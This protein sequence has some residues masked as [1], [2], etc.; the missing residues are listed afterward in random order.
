MAQSKMEVEAEFVRCRETIERAY[1]SILTGSTGGPVEG[2]DGGW[3]E[4]EQARREADVRA[5]EEKERSRRARQLEQWEEEDRLRWEREEEERRAALTRVW[6][7][8]EEE[9]RRAAALR[10]DALAAKQRTAAETQRLMLI[11]QATLR[12]QG[13]VAEEGRRAAERQAWE[14]EEASRR[15]AEAERWEAEQRKAREGAAAAASSSAAGF[16]RTDFD[17][18]GAR[19][20][21]LLAERERRSRDI[22][23]VMAKSMAT[24]GNESSLVQDM[25]EQ[26]A[27]RLQMRANYAIGDVS[28]A[29]DAATKLDPKYVSPE[30]LKKVFGGPAPLNSK[31]PGGMGGGH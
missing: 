13:A 17:D 2:E 27:A 16:E 18:E 22:T 19:K 29:R 20:R 5:W 31:K 10:F 24:A 23:K 21:E 28:K 14:A 11:Q 4:S 12:Q 30:E 1:T 7:V 26:E 15:E 25:R 9:L 3:W 8:E 6:D